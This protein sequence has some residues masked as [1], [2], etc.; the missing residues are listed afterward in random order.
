M[1]F[2]LQILCHEWIRDHAAMS[3]VAFGPEYSAR[4]RGEWASTRSENMLLLVLLLTTTTMRMMMMMMR[5]KMIVVTMTMMM[6]IMMHEDH[7]VTALIL[8][9]ILK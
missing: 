9:P 7:D 2:R 4:I 1:C 8:H 6:M 3:N 5:M